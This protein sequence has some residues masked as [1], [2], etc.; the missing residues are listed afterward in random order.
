MCV[1]VCVCATYTLWS[2]TCNVIPTGIRSPSY[3]CN[4]YVYND[5]MYVCMYACMHACMYV[6]THTSKHTYI[7]V[8]INVRIYVDSYFHTMYH[9]TQFHAHTRA[10]TH[11][12]CTHTYT[13][14][15]QHIYASTR[16]HAPSAR[17]QRPGYGG[18]WCGEY[19]DAVAHGTPR[20]LTLPTFSPRRPPPP[21]QTRARS[22]W[23]F[24]CFLACA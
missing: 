15:H 19:R 3:L 12:R 22:C 8:Y 23:R 20:A 11:P 2:L 18:A 14:T 24:L 4:I 21:P 16:T 9:Y 10:H 6:Y 7:S 5:D 17:V 13:N 1:C